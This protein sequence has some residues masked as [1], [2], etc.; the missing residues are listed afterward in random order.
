VKKTNAHAVVVSA[1]QIKRT[2]NQNKQQTNRKRRIWPIR[3]KTN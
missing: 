1:V 3:T 2:V